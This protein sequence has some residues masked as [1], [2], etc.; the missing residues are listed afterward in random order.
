MVGPPPRSAQV[1]LAER[2]DLLPAVHGLLLTVRR[3]VVVE[4][5]VAGA[6]VAMELVLLAMLLE[7]GLVLVDLLG[8]GGLVL[9]A[10]EPED[11]GREVLGVVDGRHG[12][13]RGALFLGLDDPSA[14]ALDHR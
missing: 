6:V 4:E 11:R 2:E 14:P 13:A 10:E 8:G 12:L 9:V 3:T 1:S 5:A 7:L